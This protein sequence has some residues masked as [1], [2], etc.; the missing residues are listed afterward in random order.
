MFP[1]V[2]LKILMVHPFSYVPLVAHDLQVLVPGTL[3]FSVAAIFNVISALH[4]T[5]C[6]TPGGPLVRAACP[7]SA[8]VSPRLRILSPP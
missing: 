2:S 1:R 5:G 8:L 6:E 4:L 3:L 7:F